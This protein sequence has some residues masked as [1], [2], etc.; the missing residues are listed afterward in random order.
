MDS[1]RILAAYDQ[2]SAL[3]RQKVTDRVAAFNAAYDVLTPDQK[4]Q[5]RGDLAGQMM[6]YVYPKQFAPGSTM[7]P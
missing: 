4:T 2:I 5:L 7:H 6:R 1:R 3:Y